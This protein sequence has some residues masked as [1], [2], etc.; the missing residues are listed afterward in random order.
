MT[1]LQQQHSYVQSSWKDVLN[2]SDFR[3]RRN[4]RYDDLIDIT[5]AKCVTDELATRNEKQCDKID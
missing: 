4:V 5:A 3:L 1:V 2:S